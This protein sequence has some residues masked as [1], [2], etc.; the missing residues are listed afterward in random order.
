MR[1]KKRVYISLPISG[2][3]MELVKLK[4][5]EVKELIG[6][7]HT[8]VSPL[9]INKGLTDYAK[10]MGNDVETLLN[11]DV[12]YFVRGWQTSKGCTAEYEI[13]KIYEKELMFE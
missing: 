2:R 11:C 1:K 7:N 4:V 6:K 3:P 9:D 10:C 5:K 8:P 13:A 12:V